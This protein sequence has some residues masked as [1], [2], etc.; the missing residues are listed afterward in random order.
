MNIVISLFQH[1]MRHGDG[2]YPNN[3]TFARQ[4]GVEE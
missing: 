1:E 4:F 3:L 2:I